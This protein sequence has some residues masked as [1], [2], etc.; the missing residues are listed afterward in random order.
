MCLLKSL[1]VALSVVAFS[2]V[3]AGCGSSSPRRV[4]SCRDRPSISTAEH[5]AIRTRSPEIVDATRSSE[6]AKPAVRL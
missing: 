5:L 1:R 3:L 2:A 6:K 4:R